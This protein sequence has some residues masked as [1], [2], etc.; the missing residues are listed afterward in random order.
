MLIDSPKKL[1][2]DSIYNQSVCT[3]ANCSV[4]FDLKKQATQYVQRDQSFIL[5][6]SKSEELDLYSQL[7]FI[8][9]HNPIYFSEFTKSFRQGLRFRIL[10]S[11]CHVQLPNIQKRP[12]VYQLDSR[13]PVQS[14]LFSRRLLP[15]RPQNPA[16][17]EAPSLVV[18][19]QRRH[20]LAV[21]FFV[22]QNPR[23][24]LGRLRAGLHRRNLLQ[25]GLQESV[26]SVRCQVHPIHFVR[27]RRFRLR[28]DG[29]LRLGLVFVIFA[30]R[31]LRFDLDREYF[32]VLRFE[33][34]SK[35]IH[36]AQ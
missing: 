28:L 25:P 12:G 33:L 5:K 27:D 29:R 4:I 18:S 17:Q 23:L 3:S 20:H 10:L 7:F 24:V 32:I 36:Q 11:L 31:R 6:F 35:H 2:V 1:T 26:Q 14:G 13:S 19:E 21:E 8:G 15:V 30:S 34:I 16:L 9:N 22:F